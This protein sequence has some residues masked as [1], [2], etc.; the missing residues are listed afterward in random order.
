M[1]CH[2]V[3]RGVTKQQLYHFIELLTSRCENSSSV[4]AHTSILSPCRE[5]NGKV[6]ERS[7]V[8]QDHSYTIKDIACNAYWQQRSDLCHAPRSKLRHMTIPV[9]C[10]PTTTAALFQRDLTGRISSSSA[11]SSS[12]SS[13]SLRFGSMF[14][15]ARGWLPSSITS[16]SSSSASSP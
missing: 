9:V 7:C 8:G 11:S 12:S 2:Q 10:L 16:S 14:I 4:I 15:M 1:S 3:I 6:E 13:S 5:V